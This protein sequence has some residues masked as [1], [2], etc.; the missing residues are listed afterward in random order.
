MPCHAEQLGGRVWQVVPGL[1]SA[2]PHPVRNTAAG[3]STSSRP[4]AAPGW[5]L[6]AQEE[7]HKGLGPS[8]GGGSE[9]GGPDREPR[10]GAQAAAAPSAAGGGT[11]TAPSA[12]NSGPE[13]RTPRTLFSIADILGPRLIPRGPS[14]SQLPE[15]SPGPTSPLCALEELTSKTFRGFD[16]HAPEPS[17]G[18]AQ[19]RSRTLTWPSPHLSPSGPGLDPSFT[20]APTLICPLSSAHVLGLPYPNPHLPSVSS[21]APRPL[22]G[23]RQRRGGGP[24]CRE[25]SDPL[26]R[27]L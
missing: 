3:T 8:A 21:Q 13:P 24:I 25:L 15:S 7:G 10:S 1:L 9:A 5:G 6:G 16:W 23:G 2:P 4:T 14:T 12:M 17:E 27:S 18:I 22:L 11:A 19:A 20:M 26:V